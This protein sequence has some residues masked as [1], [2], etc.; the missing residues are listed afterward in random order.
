MNIKKISIKEFLKKSFDKDRSSFDPNPKKVWPRM[1]VLFFVGLLVAGFSGLY[2]YNFFQSSE[3]VDD[4]SKKVE[5]DEELL[6]RVIVI[7]AEREKEFNDY[8]KEREVVIDP[9]E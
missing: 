8:L 6:D 9:V 5:I 3:V 4:F 7:F 2:I 1:M